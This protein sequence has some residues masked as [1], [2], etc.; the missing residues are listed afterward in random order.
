MI[1]IG[2]T[3][4]VFNIEALHLSPPRLTVKKF[5]G[6][7][8]GNIKYF[9][10]R[11]FEAAE[12]V[13][14]YILVGRKKTSDIFIEDFLLSKIQCSIFYDLV[15]GWTIHDGDFRSQKESMNGTWLYLSEEFEIFNGMVFKYNQTLIQ[16]GII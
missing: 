8:N 4:L 6:S 16:V 7:D 3:F 5:S 2:E 15:S 10:I 11:S 1:N 12:F 14:D 13:N 9:I